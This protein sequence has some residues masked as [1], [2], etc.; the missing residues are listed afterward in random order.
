[1]VKPLLTPEAQAKMVATLLERHGASLQDEHLTV[2]AKRLADNPVAVVEIASRDRTF[3]YTMEAAMARETYS[4][5]MG[6]A[7]DVCFDFLDWYLGEFGKSRR[8]LLL[9]LDF[10]PHRFGDVEIL[11]KGTLR[12]EFLDDAADAWLRGERPDVESE[13]KR[14]KGRG[15]KH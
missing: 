2:A 12:N 4:M 1:M 14:M 9:P 10:Q 8:E 5:S 7:L 13:W 6:D 11:A 15:V 3:V